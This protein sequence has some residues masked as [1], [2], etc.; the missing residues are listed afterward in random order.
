MMAVIAGILSGILGGMGIG[1]GTILIPIL[2]FMGIGQ[3]AAQA[4]NI[5]SFLPISITALFMH[6]KNSL[7]CLK[8]IIPVAIAGSIGAVGGAFLAL[9]MSTDFLRIGFGSALIIFAL[10]EIV[11]VFRKRDSENSKKTDI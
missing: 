7:L 2:H 10:S 4:A 9:R 1:G 11:S 8:A 6:K 3:R 5:I